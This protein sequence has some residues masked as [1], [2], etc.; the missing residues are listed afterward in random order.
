MT[1]GPLHHVELQ[2]PNP[3]RAIAGIGWPLEALG[4][5]VCRDWDAGHL[6]NEGSFEVRLAALAA[7]DADGAG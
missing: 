7:A 6:A 4:C 2:V 3:G 5:Q 1:R